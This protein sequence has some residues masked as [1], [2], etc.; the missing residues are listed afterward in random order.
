MSDTLYREGD[1]VTNKSINGSVYV[2][3]LVG[4]SGAGSGGGGTGYVLKGLHHHASYVAVDDHILGYYYRRLA[5]ED[6]P[7]VLLESIVE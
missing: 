3:H 5:E 7:F 6:I 1:Y 2:V 4:V